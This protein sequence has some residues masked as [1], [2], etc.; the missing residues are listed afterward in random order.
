MLWISYILLQL[1]K[2]AVNEYAE[3]FLN[4]S[5]FRVVEIKHVQD[6]IGSCNQ[7]WCISK[8][9]RFRA[10]YCTSMQYLLNVKW[11][12]IYCSKKGEFSIN[13]FN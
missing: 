12:I 3:L 2:V 5:R 1:A 6:L 13:L 4:T 11:L 10:E 9:I 8:S 7:N